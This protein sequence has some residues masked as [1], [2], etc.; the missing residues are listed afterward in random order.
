M[1]ITLVPVHAS[2]AHQRSLQVHSLSEAYVEIKR[3]AGRSVGKNLNSNVLFQSFY[4]DPIVKFVL[5]N[6][7]ASEVIDVKGFNR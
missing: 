5:I 2:G 7:D 4:T 3:H 1:A 6:L